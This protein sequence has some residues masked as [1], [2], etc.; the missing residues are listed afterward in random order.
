MTLQESNHHSVTR[1]EFTPEITTALHVA[2]LHQIDYFSRKGGFNNRCDGVS[3]R[4]ADTNV[5]YD[6]ETL[7]WK[8]ESSKV[9]TVKETLRWKQ[10]LRDQSFGAFHGPPTQS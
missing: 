2:S 8:Q 1:G 5:I 9:L 10:S 3:N 7:R 4:C 6:E